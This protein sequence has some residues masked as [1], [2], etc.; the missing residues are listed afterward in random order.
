VQVHQ[1][2]YLIE[3]GVSPSAA[4]WALGAVSLGA[5]P[6]Q[7]ALGHLSDRIGR[8]WIWTIGNSGFILCCVALILL[9]NHPLPPLLYLMVI[10][11]GSLGYGLTSVMGAI[12]A[13]I[14][15]GRNYGSIFG[16]VML[17]A[18]LGGAA[19]PWV[20]GVMYDRLGTYLPA[21]KLFMVLNLVSTVAIW[22]AAPRKVR[23]VAGRARVSAAD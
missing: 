4:A 1:T 23:C 10:A 22:L 19:G 8:E 6:G 17:T 9:R 21:F 16:T 12:P 13:E 20:T 18:I 15:E 7:I 5:V 14:F 11:Q 2:K 3:I